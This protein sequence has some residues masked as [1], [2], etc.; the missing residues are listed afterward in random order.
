MSVAVPASDSYHAVSGQAN[1]LQPTAADSRPDT[2]YN[3]DRYKKKKKK[4]QKKR[5]RRIFFE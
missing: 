2:G 1:T 3:Q 5:R 4:K